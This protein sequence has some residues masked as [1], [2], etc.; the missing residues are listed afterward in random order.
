MSTILGNIK[1]EVEKVHHEWGWFLALGIGLVALG[2]FCVIY[3]G[4][5]TLASIAALGTILILAGIAQLVLV[6]Q[7]R[8]AGHVIL[9]L[10]FGIL[11]LLVGFSLIKYPVAGTL[12]VTL[13][14]A[15]YLVFSGIFRTVYALWSQ[16]P[17]YGWAIF[18]GIIS[19]VL[20]AMLW[21]QWP[22]TALWFIG[23]AV[24]IDLIFAGIS[25]SM[26]AFRLKSLPA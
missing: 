12:T 16:L 25:W 15:A 10:L 20:G 24:G 13:L 4:L 22:I 23:F 26:F 3:E 17:G 6:F 19:F 7:A 2:V 11:A 9:Y 18:S 14:L 21:A 1:A 8:N 5:A